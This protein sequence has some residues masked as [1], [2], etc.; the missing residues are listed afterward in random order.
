MF[1]LSVAAQAQKWVH[2]GSAAAWRTVGTGI[3]T[4]EEGGDIT[5][6]FNKD[7]PGPGYLLTRQTYTDFRLTLTFCISHG[8]KSGVFLREPLRKWTT[9]GD[10]RPGYSPDGGC[11]VLIDYQD[12]ENPTGSICNKQKAKKLVGAED[13]WNDLEIIC[14]GASIRVSIAG[15]LVNRFN[16]LPE[17]PGVIGFEIPGNAPEDLVVRFRR[18]RISAVS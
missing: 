9:E 12:P 14:K 5:G 10:G 8:G 17:T 15:Q 16:Q 1:G 3:W 13:D 6:R 7:R 4:A 18:M 11:R 2:E